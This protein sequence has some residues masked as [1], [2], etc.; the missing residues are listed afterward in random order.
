MDKKQLNKFVKEQLSDKNLEKRKLTIYRMSKVTG[1]SASGISNY[2]NG[3]STPTMEKAITIL[4]YL[5][6]KVN[7]NVERNINNNSNF[8]N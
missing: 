8:E 6:F 4:E 5:G 3:K 2:K 7:I 1:I